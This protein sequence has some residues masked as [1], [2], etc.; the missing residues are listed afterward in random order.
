R[1]EAA[2]LNILVGYFGGATAFP[3]HRLR[4]TFEHRTRRDRPAHVLMISDDGITTMF[5]MD[6]RGNSGWDIAAAALAKGRAGGTMAL[7]L[8]SRINPEWPVSKALERARSEQ[9]WDIRSI[10]AMEDLIS[11]AQAFSRR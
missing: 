2:I 10:A 8:G 5:D 9:G 6:E 1:D 4:D 7:N 11:F 3:I